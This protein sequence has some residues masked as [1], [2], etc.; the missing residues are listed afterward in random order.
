MNQTQ[1]HPT[2]KKVF[3][4]KPVDPSPFSRQRVD[5]LIPFHGEYESVSRLLSS[6]L[7]AVRSNPYRITLIDDASP[8]RHFSA[9]LEKDADKDMVR[10]VRLERQVGFGGAIQAGWSATQQPWI[11]VMH[12]D[13]RVDDANWML[14]MGES[15]LRFK[16]TNPAV[17]MISART[18]NPGVGH[19]SRL[20]SVKPIITTNEMVKEQDVVLNAGF[21]PLYCVLFHREL[22]NHV[23]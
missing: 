2:E 8:N 1:Q 23:G 3:K 14:R 6:I 17:K 4:A 19:D 15:M 22:F 11:M 5:I 12:S 20:K 9:S 7:Y 18:N 21:L 13:T 16:E 10:V